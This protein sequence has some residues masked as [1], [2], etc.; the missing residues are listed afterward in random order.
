[1]L[2]AETASRS[3]TQRL[4]FLLVN[5]TAKK[6]LQFELMRRTQV[7]EHLVNINVLSD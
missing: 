4:I 6:Y 7:R 5:S 3:R 1:V 2:G